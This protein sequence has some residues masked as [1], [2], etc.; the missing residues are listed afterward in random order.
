MCQKL[1]NHLV[2]IKKALDNVNEIHHTWM[3]REFGKQQHEK[4][5]RMTSYDLIKRV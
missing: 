3:S 5:D 2:H 1:L 4:G